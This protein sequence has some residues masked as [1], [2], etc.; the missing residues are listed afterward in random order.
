MARSSNVLLISAVAF[1]AV[2]HLR[3]PAFVPP[4]V[5]RGASVVIPA[6]L[7]AAASAPAFADEIGTAAKKLA[8][9]AYPFMKEVNWNSGAY[10][11]KPGPGSAGEWVNAVD[12]AIVMG[13]AMDPELLKKGVMAHH[14]AIGAVSDANPVL[15]KA[16]FEAVLASLG[17]MIAS[18]PES[19][20]MDV[21]NAF[22]A[23]T[24]SDVPPY[25][26]STVTEGDARTAYAGLVE[27]AN[28]VKAHP[29]TPIVPSTPPALVGKI[30][31]IDAAAAKL[32]SA[33]YPFVKDVDWTS[34]LALKPLP[35]A[36]ANQVLKAIDKA[37]VMGAS[38]DGKLLRE[39]AEAHHKAIGSS[40]AKLVTTEADFQAV[41]AALGKVIA[42]VP[43]SQVMEVY[44]AFGKILNPTIPNYLY[45]SVNPADAQAAYVGLLQFKDVVKAAQR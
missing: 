30:S 14:K 26:M 43:T 31:T 41:N 34:D 16:D 45:S 12:K 44:N 13:A 29:I 18:V 22:A 42:S 32:S 40:D 33:A 2:Y 3:Q 5:R 36:S 1:A 19:A 9:L 28:V 38:M 17:R 7:A 4:A 24:S 35:G 27:F 15:S 25:L 21:Y 10:L 23:L 39:A 8:D 11:V 6:T 37:L 20:T